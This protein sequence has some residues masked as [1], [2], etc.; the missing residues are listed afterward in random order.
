MQK[1]KIVIEDRTVKVNS[2]IA[3]YCHDQKVTS[4][5]KGVERSIAKKYKKYVYI[6][7]KAILIQETLTLL[8]IAK[9]IAASGNL[10]N[11]QKN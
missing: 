4:Y 7:Y 2:S 11:Y 1:C 5:V 3:N 8:K 6:K 9:N 10:Q